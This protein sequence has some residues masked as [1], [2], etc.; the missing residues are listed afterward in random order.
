MENRL[1]VLLPTHHTSPPPPPPNPP[2]PIATVG[3]VSFIPGRRLSEFEQK[4]EEAERA[5]IWKLYFQNLSY[6]MP[7]SR[8]QLIVMIKHFF[9]RDAATAQ[10]A[11]QNV[12]EWPQL[13]GTG[14]KALDDYEQED[15]SVS[16]DERPTFDMDSM[17]WWN[18]IEVHTLDTDTTGIFNLYPLRLIPNTVSIS[19][20]ASLV[21][22]LA[23]TNASESG[24]PDAFGA[25]VQLFESACRRMGGCEYR[26]RDAPFL[27][28]VFEFDHPRSSSTRDD[29][30]WAAWV[31]SATVAPVVHAIVTKS[32]M[33]ASPALC[34]DLCDVCD[35]IMPY[36]NADGPTPSDVVQSVETAI[37]G[38]PNG[39]MGS[40]T[41]VAT[42]VEDEMCI[43]DVSERAA[44]SL[45]T[46]AL[47]MESVIKS[48]T[49]ANTKLWDEVRNAVL[50]NASY[51]TNFTDR[52][53]A[54]MDAHTSSVGNNHPPA[55]ARTHAAENGRRLEEKGRRSTLLSPVLGIDFGDNETRFAEWYNGITDGER[56]LFATSATAAHELMNGTD[57]DVVVR[58]HFQALRAWALVGAHVGT[59]ANYSGVCADPHI[60]NRTI[61]C[62]AYFA[63]MGKE[64]QRGKRRVQEER[65]FQ[66][67]GK[68][69][70]RR[71]LS[72]EH[73]RQLKESVE[74]HL[75]NVCCA[76]FESDGRVECGRRFCEHHVMR[77]TLRRMGHVLRKLSDDDNH[78]AQKKITPDV[79]S[80]LENYILPELHDDPQCRQINRSTLDVGGPTRW[81]CMGKSLLKHAAKK[82]GL[83]S[84][85]IEKHM[86]TMGLSVGK[87][88]QSVHKVTGVIREVRGSGNVIRKQFNPASK[89]RTEGAKRAAEL[90]RSAEEEAG[91]GRRLSIHHE[92]SLQDEASLS[93]E[94]LAR[95][96]TVTRGTVSL[97]GTRFR[98]FGHAARRMADTRRDRKNTTRIIN[99]QFRRLEDREHRDRLERAA[100][101]RAAHTRRDKAPHYDSFHWDNFKQHVINPVFAFEVLQ[102]EHGSI[103]SRLRGGLSKLSALSER[104]SGLNFEASL[105]EVQRRRQRQRRLAESEDG[106][107]N[108]AT[109]E[110]RRS[111]VRKLYDELDRRQAKR[112]KERRKRLEGVVENGRVLSEHEI[113]ARAATPTLELPE[114]HSFSFMHEIIDWEAAA[115]EWTRVK[116]IVQ[117]RNQMRYEGRTMKEILGHNPTGYSWLDDHTRYGFSK[118]GDAF[119]R[120][121][122]RKTNGTDQGHVDHVKSKNDHA[123]SHHPEK[124]GRARRLAESFLGPVVAAP[125]AFWDTRLFKGTFKEIKVEPKPDQD[126]VFVSLLRYIVFSTVGCYLTEPKVQVVSTQKSSDDDPSETVDGTKLKVLKP[127]DQWMCFP[128]IP[129][130]LPTLPTWREWTKTEGVDYSKITYEVC[131]RRLPYCPNMRTY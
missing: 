60:A 20:A 15:E 99:E 125:Y 124:H 122:H 61:S 2:P 114:K 107:S 41:D 105:S 27:N 76:E 34:G 73:H 55:W 126:N 35:G 9:S 106:N 63:L 85:T 98:G 52:M 44:S 14:G 103:S 130:A 16:E 10:F 50:E 58:A 3:T 19:P 94:E 66:A 69:F 51:Y 95:R 118:V 78:P 36:T 111:V 23:L 101:G 80:T 83:D 49:V 120:M 62:R 26:S 131:S 57:H 102:A 33:C 74:E 11:T 70:D 113:H 87:A 59:N 5:E 82:H 121:W 22:A 42:C 109:L 93:D 43:A 91:Q 21:T 71:R 1:G 39:G 110:D 75:E 45:K 117:K 8:E 30:E 90:I 127:D 4:V 12:S 119:R 128:A 97:P 104:W 64:L 89:L 37:V 72:Q 47:P 81:E 115:D 88:M 53:I 108:G 29:G 77:N 123:G 17:N 46:I 38:S 6:P 100:S 31:L 40:S 13:L 84:K 28:G 68:R 129:W 48:I 96:Q 79:L 67:S 116:D 56:L 24:E 7:Q 32:L 112:A 25:E 86:N 92:R 54:A 18:N 65:E